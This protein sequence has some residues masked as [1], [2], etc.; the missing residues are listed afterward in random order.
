MHNSCQLK[1]PTL[2]RK[3]KVG[4]EYSVEHLGEFLLEL[5]NVNG[6]N[7]ELRLL[8]QNFKLK[9]VLIKHNKNIFINYFTE[10]Y[11]KYVVLKCRE[12][13]YQSLK[14]LIEKVSKYPK[15]N[16]TKSCQFLWTR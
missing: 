8:D 7:F 4:V 2:I 5:T 1:K 16:Y 15:F 6:P 14:I 3:R 12:N 9:K 10:I 11:E 13:G